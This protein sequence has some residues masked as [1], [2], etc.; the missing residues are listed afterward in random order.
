MWQKPHLSAAYIITEGALKTIIE[1]IK[2]F[3]A[4]K[5]YFSVASLKRYLKD[6]NQGYKNL[7][8][9]QHLYNLKESREIFSCGY[10][11]YSTIG[12]YLDIDLEPV[13]KYV[14]TIKS[15][16]PLLEFDVWSTRQLLRFFHHMP[17]RY[18][19]FI[20]VEYDGL[21]PV[22]ELLLDQE[23]T[24]YNNPDRDAVMKHLVLKEETVIVRPL[25]TETPTQT[26]QKSVSVDNLHCAIIEKM[27]VDLYVEKDKMIY[28]DD[29]E[30]ERVLRN[31]LFTG[32][33]NIP[34]LLR[35]ARRREVRKYFMN[36]LFPTGNEY[37]LLPDREHK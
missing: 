8:V 14:K 36:Y 21:M 6:K 28:M 16:F 26:G 17:F 22:Y 24:V 25:I 33:I 12:A 1:K 10:G 4:D 18:L 2:E 37:I 15:K 11:W 7:T 32:R 35:Y 20:Y 3:I 23:Y 29:A 34:T 9:N 31:V 13:E 27:L 30:Y 19:I 5:A